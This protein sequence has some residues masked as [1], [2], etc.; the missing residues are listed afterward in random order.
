MFHIRLYTSIRW[1]FV[2]KYTFFLRRK[3]P[4]SPSG[5]SRFVHIFLLRRIVDNRISTIRKTKL[6]IICLKLAQKVCNFYVR[7]CVCVYVWMGL[8]Y[9]LPLSCQQT[10]PIVAFLCGVFLSEF[11]NFVS[12]PLSNIDISCTTHAARA[13]PDR[14]NAIHL[15]NIRSTFSRTRIFLENHGF[16]FSFFASRLTK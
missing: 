15:R 6:L 4:F 10:A 12:T 1:K 3:L 5:D 16:F 11:P 8:H 2:R 14:Y 9:Q 13:I 7:V